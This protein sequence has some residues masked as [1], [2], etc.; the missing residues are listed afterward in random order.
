MKKNIALLITLILISGIETTLAD[1]TPTKT[2]WKCVLDDEIFFLITDGDDGKVE[3]K[4]RQYPA[5]F[6]ENQQSE[7]VWEMPQFSSRTVLNKKT[8][9]GAVTNTG[10]NPGTGT[11]S[12]S[13]Q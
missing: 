6:Y 8:G 9:E 1:E 3:L 11:F 10:N 2:I 13:K 12:C 4:G 5:I 7:L